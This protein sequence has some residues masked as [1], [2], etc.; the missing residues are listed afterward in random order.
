MSINEKSVKKNAVLNVIYTVTNMVFPLITYPYVSRILLSEGTGKVNFF[1]SI[2][3]YAVMVGSLG[4]GTY[5]IRV[6]A[7]TR[8]DKEQLSK[9][10]SELLIINTIITVLVAILLFL[11]S[12]FINKFSAEPQ[13]FIINL[14]IILITPLGMNWL[15]SGM[16]QYEYITKRTIVFK[17][18]SLV[19]VFVF[20]RN[21]SDYPIYAAILAFST[22]GSYICNLIYSRKLFKFYISKNFDYKRHF[23]PM[24]LLFG[25]I[26]AVSVYTNLDTIMLGF[27]IDDVQVGLY[28]VASKSKW[29][30]LAAVNAISAV[31][32]PRLSNYISQND[33]KKYNMTL[34][35][36]ISFIF[37]LTIPISTFFIVESADT[38]GILG[39]PDYVGAVRGMQILMPILIISGFSNVTGNQVL[40]PHGKDSEFLKAVATG[41][42]VDVILNICLMPSLG[43]TGAAIATLMAELVQS[44]IQFYYAKK[45][46]INN[47]YFK[48][49]AKA[50]VGSTIACIVA[51]ICRRLIELNIVISFALTGIV[52]FVIYG[53]VLLILKEE[54]AI[55]M[56]QLVLRK[57]A[58]KKR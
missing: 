10:T 27:I 12:F 1:T 33:I 19:L 45:Y 49:I 26:L 32:L 55:E 34:K 21:K 47:I 8:D 7:K 31:L 15:Y 20:V 56:I 14:L 43:C 2:S 42:V 37:V 24:L 5:G 17:V 9:V 13:L 54:Y 30:L 58:H 36:S 52:F 23:K 11:S 35:K 22:V 29:I 16:E 18:I 40:I 28:G 39:G 46:I 3:N 44:S 4:L 57:T 50:V 25:S 53:I 51:V 48:T 6:V 41:A 38:V